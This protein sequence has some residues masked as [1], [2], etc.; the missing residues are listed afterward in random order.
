MK[1]IFL[2]ITLVAVSVCAFAQSA[3][4]GVKGGVNFA[5]LSAQSS[6]GSTTYTTGQLT[7]F[8]VGLFADIKFAGLSLQP[9]LIYTGKGGQEDDNNGN[10]AQVKL[11]YLQVPVNLV[12]HIPAVIGNVYLGAGPYAAYGVSGKTKVITS[13]GSSVSDNVTFGDGIDDIKR[14]DIGLNGIAGIEFKNNFL[15]GLNYDLGLTNISN[16]NSV[17]TKTR[18]FGISAGF[19]F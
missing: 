12:Y 10:V 17:T 15:I 19:K 7:T 9:A 16:D 14:T 1:K 6:G 4:L 5:N 3:S 13:G 2:S 18:V 8:S 11:Y